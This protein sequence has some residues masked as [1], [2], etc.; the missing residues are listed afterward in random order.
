MSAN[1]INDTLDAADDDD[2]DIDDVNEVE[3]DA[4]EIDD[5]NHDDDA[6]EIENG[7]DDDSVT[8]GIDSSPLTIQNIIGGTSGQ[9]LTNG[10]TGATT[11]CCRSPLK[12]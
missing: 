1:G 9:D 11:T 5:D 3:D 7:I 4:N 12:C 8:G 2:N 6:G 10:T